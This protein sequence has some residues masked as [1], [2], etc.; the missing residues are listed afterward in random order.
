MVIQGPAVKVEQDLDPGSLTFRVHVLHLSALPPQN[1]WFSESSPWP[2]G[3]LAQTF[4]VDPTGP[5]AGP[6]AQA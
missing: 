1:Y 3:E 2:C 6:G 4:W 5:P